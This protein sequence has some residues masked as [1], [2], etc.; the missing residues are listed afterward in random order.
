M[1]VVSDTSAITSLIKIGRVDLLRQ[2][3]GQVLIPS[4]VLAELEV[5]HMDLPVWVHKRPVRDRSLVL[6]LSQDLDW[7]ESEAIALAIE[8]GAD[9]LLI[10]EKLGR[11]E[12]IERGIEIIGVLGVAVV[13]KNRGLIDSVGIFIAHL[14]G[15]ASFRLSADL[16]MRI[17]RDAGEA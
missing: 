4:A 7:G 1:I 16:E 13:A 15:Q 17:L 2:I 12:A 6:E 14:K 11:L 3:F 5:A 8:T 9:F 10:D